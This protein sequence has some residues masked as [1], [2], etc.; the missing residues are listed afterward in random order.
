VL[1]YEYD[2]T[3]GSSK[4]GVFKCQLFS[5]GVTPADIAQG[6]LGDCWLL[7]AFACLAEF[8]G[9]VKKVCANHPATRRLER[10]RALPPHRAR[11]S[12]RLFKSQS[13]WLPSLG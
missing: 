6:Q 2:H 12:C 3:G 8:E 5:G 7:S 1:R 9:A 13:C 4:Y 11:T 10:S